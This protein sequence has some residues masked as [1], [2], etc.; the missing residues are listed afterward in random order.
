MHAPQR[1]QRSISRRAWSASI[2]VR[3]L[4]TRTTCIASGPSASPG[5]FGPQ[6]KVVYWVSSPPVAERTRRRS[7]AIACAV[8]GS[9]FS[10]PAVTMWTLG[11]VVV[12]SALPSLV[13]VQ[14]A[15]VSAIR[16]LA[17][18]M[19]TSAERNFARSSRR[20]LATRSSASSPRGGCAW[21]ALNSS[22]A[23]SRVRC[24]AGQ[25]M[26]D[27]GSP[28]SWMMCS[29]R[30]VSTRSTPASAS[31]CGRPISS[32]SIDL[33]RV[34]RRAP[35]SRQMATTIRQASSAVAAQCTLL[36]AAVAFFS[37]SSR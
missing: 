1:M 31:A 11:G 37:N 12:S 14:A 27:G 15:P 20:A 6:W 34:T 10:M 4:S 18:E 7:I 17:P 16:K 9:S 23:C 22:A 25:T 8:E 2:R 5:R 13:T 19:P 21:R 26:W 36:P 33:A 29:A 30:S 28:A 35:A 32:P 24:M 3:P